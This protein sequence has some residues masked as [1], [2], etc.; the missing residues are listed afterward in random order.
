MVGAF[1][2]GLIGVYERAPEDLFTIA[3]NN[4]VSVPP[5][6]PSLR[7]GATSPGPRGTWQ[8]SP[9]VGAHTRVAGD[10]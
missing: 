2:I 7:Y 1:A 10:E 8:A 5:H 4:T 3:K 9:P 6:P